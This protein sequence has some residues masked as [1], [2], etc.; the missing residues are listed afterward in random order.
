MVTCVALTAVIVSAEDCPDVMVVG[1][2]LIW[3]VG[4]G[5]GVTVTVADA[6]AFPPAPEPEAVYVVVDPGLTACVPPVACSV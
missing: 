3:T 5:L 2:A 1:F 6:E 4:G